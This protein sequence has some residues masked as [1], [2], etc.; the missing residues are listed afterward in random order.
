MR[1]KKN[2]FCV[3]LLPLEAVLTEIVEDFSGTV[4]IYIWV[5]HLLFSS[6]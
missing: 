3:M 4:Y 1:E 2:N 6:S 5:I